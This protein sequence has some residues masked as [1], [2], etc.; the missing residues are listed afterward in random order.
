[1]VE[2]RVKLGHKGQV[3]IPKLLREQFKLYPGEEV[4]MKEENEGVLITKNI[5]DPIEILMK[6]AKEATK[7]RGGEP[8]KYNKQEF[9]EQHEKRLKHSNLI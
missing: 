3:V 4:L 8:L 6:T 5:E 1:M 2:L 9:Y 7:K